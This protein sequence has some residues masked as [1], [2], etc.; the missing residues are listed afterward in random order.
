MVTF[1][2]DKINAKDAQKYLEG[3]ETRTQDALTA[4]QLDIALIIQGEVDEIFNSAPSG[5]SGGTVYGGETWNALSEAYLKRRPDR[6]S[7]QIYRDTGELLQ[8]LSVGVS[9]NVFEVSNKELTFG[10]NLVKAPRLNKLRK[11]L[12][13]TPN[14]NTAIQKRV[15]I[16]I[17]TGK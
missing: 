14:M 2:V 1:N 8:S 16:Y 7:G 13:V 15:N 17:K 10:T 6:A 4:L 3:F 5:A 11:F 12:Y 9:G